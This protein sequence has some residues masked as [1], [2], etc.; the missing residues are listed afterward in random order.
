SL[1]D[2][3]FSFNP[4]PKH[5]LSSATQ[6]RGGWGVRFAHSQTPSLFVKSQNSLV[7]LMLICQPVIANS[8]VVID[9][10]LLFIG[11]RRKKLLKRLEPARERTRPRANW[12]IASE[13]QPIRAEDFQHMLDVRLKI[14]RFP[15]VVVGFGD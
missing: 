6:W 4:F 14:G 12:K 15:V 8:V 13:H 11:Q 9:R 2:E 10:L 7:S 1:N 5:V 3:R